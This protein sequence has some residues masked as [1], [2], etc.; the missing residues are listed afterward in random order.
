MR[1]C[2]LYSTPRM[3]TA[4]NPL[5]SPRTAQPNYS[6]EGRTQSATYTHYSKT[7]ERMEGFQMADSRISQRHCHLAEKHTSPTAPSRMQTRP[8]RQRGTLIVNKAIHLDKRIRR[9]GSNDFCVNSRDRLMGVKTHKSWR[10]S[11]ER[12]QMLCIVGC[13]RRNNCPKWLGE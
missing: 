7:K 3:R 10:W 11:L 9:R 13:S 1:K 2:R 4:E 5:S 6:S 8:S 12:N